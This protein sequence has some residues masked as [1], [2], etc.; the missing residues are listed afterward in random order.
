MAEDSLHNLTNNNATFTNGKHKPTGEIAM[1]SQKLI[2]ENLFG[3]KFAFRDKKRWKLEKD[4][5]QSD[6]GK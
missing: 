3:T 2:N 6:K 1:Q 5:T 4:P